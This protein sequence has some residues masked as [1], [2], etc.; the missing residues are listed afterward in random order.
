MNNITM[1]G[2]NPFEIFNYKN[3]G[4]VRTRLD[5]HGNPWFCLRDICDILNIQNSHR[6]ADRLSDPYVTSITVWV[7]TGFNADGTPAT[8]ATEMTFINESN[9]CRV[10]L[11]SKKAEA[12][13]FSDWIC[14]DVIPMI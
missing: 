1:N 8:R 13:L 12:K 9:L 6:V 14:N 10:V 4:S 11:G 3:L 7:Q 5:E 2:N